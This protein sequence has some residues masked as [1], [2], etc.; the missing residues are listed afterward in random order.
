[1]VSGGC[2]VLG[3]SGIGRDAASGGTVLQRSSEDVVGIM[4]AAEPRYSWYDEESGLMGGSPS[5]W[6]G[7]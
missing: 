7:K 2:Q 5:R 6:P 4:L 3:R 1:M